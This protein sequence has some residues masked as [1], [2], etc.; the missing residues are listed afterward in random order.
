MGN[1]REQRGRVVGVVEQYDRS[2]PNA[3]R[4]AWYDKMNS[5]WTPLIVTLLVC[6]AYYLA[7]N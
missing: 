5:R 3:N 6:A 1:Q 7:E 4:D 2:L